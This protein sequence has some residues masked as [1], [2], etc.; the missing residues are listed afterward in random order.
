MF[1][2]EY[3]GFHVSLTIFGMQL[4]L[5][6][7]CTASCNVKHEPKARDRSE[8]WSREFCQWMEDASVD[9]PYDAIKSKDSKENAP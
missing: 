1:S 5:C 8:V 2:N 7:L 4:P 3:L 6:F 9:D